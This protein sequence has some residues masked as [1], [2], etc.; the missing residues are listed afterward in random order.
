MGGRERWTAQR[1]AFQLEVDQARRRALIDSRAQ[2]ATSVDDR[3]LQAAEA[4]LALDTLRLTFLVKEQR[5][6]QGQ[7]LDAR[8]LARLASIPRVL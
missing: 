4:G 8:D 7:S 3:G 1:E 5:A 2:R 6:L